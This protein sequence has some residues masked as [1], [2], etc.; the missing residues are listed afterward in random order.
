MG[1]ALK[2]VE[3]KQ[4]TLSADGRTAQAEI[5]LGYAG[6]AIKATRR[7]LFD[8][9]NVDGLWRVTTHKPK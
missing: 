2:I 6:P 7:F 3:Y 9:E 5:R 4:F 8:F 1:T